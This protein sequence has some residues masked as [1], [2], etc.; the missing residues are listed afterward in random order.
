[1]I[2]GNARAYLHAK[3]GGWGSAGLSHIE[4]QALADL[5][6][7]RYT[8]VPNPAAHQ[9]SAPPAAA[10][11]PPPRADAPARRSGVTMADLDALLPPRGAD[12]AR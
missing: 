9:A 12:A 8:G 2:G 4:P 11:T 5:P 3:L 6:T 7:L 1:M 10:S